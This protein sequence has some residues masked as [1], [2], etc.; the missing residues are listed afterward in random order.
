LLVVARPVLRP[1]LP[2]LYPGST[3]YGYVGRY[4]STERKQRWREQLRSYLRAAAYIVPAAI[5]LTILSQGMVQTKLERDYPTP[6]EWTFWSRWGLRQARFKEL[7]DDAKINGVVTDWPRAGR[8]YLAVLERLESEKYDGK[9]LIREGGAAG[10]TP[11]A[12]QTEGFD[13]SAKSEQWRR[14]YHETLMGVAHVAENLVGMARLKGDVRGGRVYPW[15]SIPGPN[16]PRPKPLPFDKKYGRVQAPSFEEV[17]DAF[18]SPDVVY[19]KI[20][21]TGGFDTRQRLDAALAYAD[22]NDFRGDK[23]VAENTYMLAAEIAQHGLSADLGKVI[24]VGTGMILKGKEDSV[25]DNILRVSTAFGVHHARTGDAKTALPVFLSVLKARKNLPASPIS[26]IRAAPVT[27]AE[28]EEGIWAY[29]SALQDLVLERPYPP[30][31]PS[32]NERPFHTL[33]EACEE[34]GLMTYIGEILF[35]T[36]PSE[37]AKG[38][39]W[40]RDSVEAAEAI[41][42]VMDEQKEQAGRERCREC[43]QTGLQNWKAMA[44]QMAKL[45]AKKEADIQHSKSGTFGLGFGVERHLERARAERQLWEEENAQIELRRQKT[46]PLLQE[47]LG[48]IGGAWLARHI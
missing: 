14:G 3:R 20:L 5:L 12:I 27:P 28:S 24:N 25:S 9:N 13:V 36:S 39:S 7:S 42:W 40:T 8:Y 41:M 22:W 31:P 33:K 32:G 38:L 35:A 6:P 17:E 1:Q 4:I 16:N 23:D 19:Q 30:P 44:Q 29:V 10:S 11:E 37:R 46:L 48:P 18:P 21:N 43:L 2:F 26:P 15:E 47:R 34:V 45:A